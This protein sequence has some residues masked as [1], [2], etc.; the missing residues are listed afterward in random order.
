MKKQLL[1]IALFTLGTISSFAQFYPWYNSETVIYTPQAQ[2][3]RGVFATGVTNPDT[4][5]LNTQATTAAFT[6]TLGTNNNF[7]SFT[8]P[9]PI[10]KA[11]MATTKIRIKINYTGT[12][13]ATTFR[14]RMR[15]AEGNSVG[16]FNKNGTLTASEGTW[17]EYTI[18]Y[19]SGLPANAPDDYAKLLIVFNFGNF[20]TS[21][22]YH[23]DQI[24]STNDQ[25]APVLSIGGLELGQSELILSPSNVSE[26]FKISKEILSA[27]VYNLMGQIVKTYE[28]NQNEYNA[29]DLSSGVYLLRAQLK[30]GTT[31]SIRFVKK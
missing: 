17:G 30:S 1:T 6:P 8:L 24:R 28:N 3:V 23:I 4:S 27:E 18:N 7:I 12:P 13:P 10:A 20:D 11:D 19:A 26:V 21:V 9:H 16:Q 15:D 22:V 5:G 25:S 14:V 2:S 31:Q 29:S